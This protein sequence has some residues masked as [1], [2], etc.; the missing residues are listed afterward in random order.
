MKNYNKEIEEFK[1][2]AHSK[3]KTHKTELQTRY[4]N[5]QIDPETLEKGYEEHR[6]I[7]EQEL[8]EKTDVVLSGEENSRLKDELNNISSDI[9]KQLSITHS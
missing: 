9:I 5:E 4:G 7:L 3:L 1:F 2:F 8:R 6:K